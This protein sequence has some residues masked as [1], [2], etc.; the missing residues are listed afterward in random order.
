MAGVPCYNS[1][2]F[3]FNPKNSHFLKK[4]QLS[5]MFFTETNFSFINA[6]RVLK[7][8]ILRSSFLHFQFVTVIFDILLNIWPVEIIKTQFLTH[9]S[10]TEACLQLVCLFLKR[11]DG[12]PSTT[13]TTSSLDF[14][15]KEELEV[16]KPDTSLSVS[17]VSSVLSLLLS[18]T[19]LFGKAKSL[20]K[21]FNFSHFWLWQLSNFKQAKSLRYLVTRK[22]FQ[23]KPA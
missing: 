6:K 21:T 22:S 8:W 13:G 10:S 2:K 1:N 12:W 11:Q 7:K 4:C 23:H 17:L 9:S 16:V 3:F 20:T 5:K 15:S 18:T 14:S 19:F